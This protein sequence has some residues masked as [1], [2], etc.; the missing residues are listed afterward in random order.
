VQ[1]YIQNVY[2]LDDLDKL[3][4]L[5]IEIA[6][7][8]T[9]RGGVT[10]TLAAL[11][12]GHG[13][14]SEGAGK[15]ALDSEERQSESEKDGGASSMIEAEI[16]RKMEYHRDFHFVVGA[17]LLRGMPFIIYIYIYFSIISFFFLKML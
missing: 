6:P 13:A 8:A 5:S 7:R 11:E 2:Y 12:L 4:K 10:G 14:D 1:K 16:L 17:Y 9:K 3:Y 15:A